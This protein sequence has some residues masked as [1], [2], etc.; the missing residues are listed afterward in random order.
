MVQSSENHMIKMEGSKITLTG[1]IMT[2]Q[3]IE[4]WRS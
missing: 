3:K 1:K 2:P 4:Y